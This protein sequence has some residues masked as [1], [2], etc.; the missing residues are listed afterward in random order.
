MQRRMSVSLFIIGF[1]TLL[2]LGIFISSSFLKTLNINEK[3]TQL[4][5]KE[6]PTYHFVLIGEEADNDYWRLVEKGAKEAENYFDV[7]VE[8]KGPKRSNIKEHLKLIDMA[9]AS[10]VDGII[11]QALTEEEFVPAINRAIESGIPVVTIDTDAPSSDRVAYI[12]TDNYYS[13]LLAGKALIEDT[14]GEV[15]VGIITGNF[16][17]EHQQLRV[18]GFKDMIKDIERIKVVAVEESNISRLEAEQKAYQLLRT[19]EEINAFYG[20]SALDGIG[21]VAAKNKVN[22]NDLYIIAF[23]TLD[24][25]IK[26][27]EGNEIHA[28]V[29]QKPFEMGFKSVEVLMESFIYQPKSIVNHTETKII[30]KADLPDLE[31]E[32]HL[33][34]E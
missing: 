24:E 28:V 13:G 5:A 32:M 17:S 27:L 23:D 26:L 18:Q 6:L 21:I 14:E 8:Y 25:T 1:V 34:R 15:S 29:V 10:K 7:H 30:R 16:N 12:G 20:T 33:I 4:V 9:V 22:V 3:L 31:T 11:T 2:S 19:Y